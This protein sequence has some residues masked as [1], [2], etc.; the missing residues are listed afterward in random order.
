MTCTFDKI[1]Q[2]SFEI[3]GSCKH[4]PTMHTFLTIFSF[5]TDRHIQKTKKQKKSSVFAIYINVANDTIIRTMLYLVVKIV[6]GIY[7]RWFQN[8]GLRMFYI[9]HLDIWHYM[10]P[11][12]TEKAGRVRVAY[13]DAGKFSELSKN[14]PFS[15]LFFF[16][17]FPMQK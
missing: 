14:N 2:I 6:F 5:I 7:L 8:I 1:Q 17:I 10:C 3:V 12:G 4:I 16:Q 9:F 11:Y 13:H 15:P